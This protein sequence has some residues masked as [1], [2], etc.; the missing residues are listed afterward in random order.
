MQGIILGA[1]YWGFVITQIPAGYLAGRFGA[2][3]I[4]GGALLFSSIMV[5]FIPISTKVHW[6]LFCV[7]RFLIGLAHGT[8][9]PCMT[10]IMARWAPTSER[11]K[12]MSFVNAGN[13]CY[14]F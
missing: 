3:F 14:F 2:R 7:L 5:M 4:F 8:I 9:W 12:L 6:A 13:F 10:V 1:Y 11:G